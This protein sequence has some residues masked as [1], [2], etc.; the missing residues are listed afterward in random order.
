MTVGGTA[1]H[2]PRWGERLILAA[3]APGLLAATVLIIVLTIGHFDWRLS[4]GLL[5]NVF[6]WLAMSTPMLSLLAGVTLVVGAVAA[7][8]LPGRTRYK[9]IALT[10]GTM[11]WG[12]AFY[13]LSV[14]GLIDLP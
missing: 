5:G 4:D 1:A 8:F 2:H 11:A 7:P 14:P 13:W 3:A 9:W 6:A 12:L 10:L